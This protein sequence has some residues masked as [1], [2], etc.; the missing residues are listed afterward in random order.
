[1]GKGFKV[2]GVGLG[3]SGG[4]SLAKALS[5]LGY[6]ISSNPCYI[7]DFS[8]D[9]QDGTVDGATA[10][11][12]QYLDIRFPNSKFILTTKNLTDWLD[13]A[14]KELDGLELQERISKGL[15][16]YEPTVRSISSNW[17]CSEYREDY[18]IQKY[19]SHHNSVVSYFAGRP[20]KLIVVD[21]S[22]PCGWKGICEHLGEP[23][24]ECP[25]P[26]VMD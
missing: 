14:K 10:L 19:Y 1:M 3:K 12:Y 13:L 20:D 4:R 17:G 16:I 23:I 26:H 7:D 21:T 5:S 15:H 22:S 2:W 24:P 6:K 25:F 8:R 11:H 9:N 18:L